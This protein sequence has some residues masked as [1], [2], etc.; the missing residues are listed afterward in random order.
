MKK[1]IGFLVLLPVLLINI[2][3]L[4]RHFI[5]G[6]SELVSVADTMLNDS[7]I[8]VGYVHW[9]DWPVNLSFPGPSEIWVENTTL[10]TVGDPSGYYFIK[11][12]P[13]TYTIKCQSE[14]NEWVQL[15]DEMKNIVIT[16][17]RKIRI[18]FYIGYTIE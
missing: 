14:G 11:I 6:R 13:G 9:V 16:R 17:D 10:S 5:Q 15:V 8:F 2:S 12:I 3:C 18:D 4:N 7:A 1:W